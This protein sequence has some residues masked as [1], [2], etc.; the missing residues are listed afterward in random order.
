M[1]GLKLVLE[2]DPLPLAV[3]LVF[4]PIVGAVGAVAQAFTLA[5]SR[6]ER[7]RVVRVGV[8]DGLEQGDG[9]M[10]R[11]DILRPVAARNVRDGLSQTFMIG[12]DLPEKN[13]WC[14]WPYA[15]NAYGTC[16]I[17]P[18]FSYRDPNW[19]P[20]THSFRSAH[21][22]GLNFAMADGSVHFIEQ[23][24]ALPV[25]RALATRAGQETV[26]DY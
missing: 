6:R 3:V 2:L 7:G 15:N 16:A 10:W 18:N 12:E 14:S 1:D 8:D 22:G 11:S 19:W 25:Y 21:P 13:R 9:I 23:G 5:L 26:S 17:P 4:Y 24:I 20:N